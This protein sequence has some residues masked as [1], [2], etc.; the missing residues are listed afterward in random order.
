MHST[1]QPWSSGWQDLNSLGVWLQFALARSR[2]PH[3]L[4]PHCRRCLQF[5]DNN[6]L[7]TSVLRP[8]TRA[9]LARSPRDSAQLTRSE[10][11][12]SDSINNPPPSPSLNYLELHE[13]V[14]RNQQLL[15][16]SQFRLANCFRSR[17]CIPRENG[18][19]RRKS[20]LK[21]GEECC[22]NISCY[23]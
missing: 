1:L 8:L 15:V 4:S 2:L 16:L 11:S 6:H 23:P 20:N 19:P 14:L 7:Y 21:S 18:L 9:I 12:T 5:N 10:I 3:H 17:F 22:E 13:H